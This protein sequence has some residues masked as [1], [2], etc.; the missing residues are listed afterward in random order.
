MVIL[1]DGF[2]YSALTQI[3]DSFSCSPLFFLFKNKLL[4]V[5]EYAMQFHMKMSLKHNNVVT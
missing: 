5:P 1:R 3:M 4:E 2:F